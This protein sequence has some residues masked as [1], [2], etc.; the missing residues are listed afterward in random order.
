[1][2]QGWALDTVVPR[3]GQRVGIQCWGLDKP[4]NGRD[5][6]DCVGNCGEVSSRSSHGFPPFPCQWMGASRCMNCT[7]LPLGEFD[8]QPEA[9]APAGQL[10]LP[11]G[12]RR[13]LLA[14]AVALRSHWAC[15]GSLSDLEQQP[16]GLHHHPGR[17]AD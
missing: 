7:L 3:L 12:A 13:G 16:P 17:V 10:E 1:M 2:G 9:R 8:M 6:Q 11:K 15:A 14:V 5:G 4:Q